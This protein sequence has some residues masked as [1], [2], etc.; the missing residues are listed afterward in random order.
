MWYSTKKMA[1]DMDAFRART[2]NLPEDLREQAFREESERGWGKIESCVL[3]FV[4]GR[5]IIEYG[6]RF[7]TLSL[8]TWL[9]IVNAANV[10][11][12]PI[13]AA[14]FIDFIETI[15]DGFAPVPLELPEQYESVPAMVRL[16]FC[17][18]QAIKAG[19]GVRGAH[20][21]P[22]RGD[23]PI[24]AKMID[25]K[26]HFIFDDRTAH[27]VMEYV[28][29]IGNDGKTTIPIWWRPWFRAIMV[30][31]PRP[32]F[33]GMSEVDKWPLEW[34]VIVQGGKIAAISVYYIQAAVNASPEIGA[35]VS[36]VRAKSEAILAVM[37]EKKIQ[38]W[39]PMYIDERD[40]TDVSFVM[41]FISTENH[42]NL[43]LEAG[44]AVPVTENN[45]P[46]EEGWGAH[47]CCFIGHKIDG[48]RLEK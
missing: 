35:I 9:E 44:P 13:M 12:V 21:I 1:R 7:D 18:S 31:A 16:D 47:P 4:A 34:R 6:G 8:G 45:I 17:G 46:D 5:N 11:A 14:A 23:A 48:V 37:A 3:S 32:K 24:G 10:P 19:F 25:G 22:K 30:D 40:E 15:K 29:Q 39:H 26:P 27:G 2:D 38:P 20:P 42:G 41:D 28:G 36:D 33:M 43:F